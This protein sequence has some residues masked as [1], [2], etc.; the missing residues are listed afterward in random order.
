M[1]DTE[2]N[3]IEERVVTKDRKNG[4]VVAV[5]DATDSLS[6]DDVLW[7]DTKMKVI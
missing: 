3:G 5:V 1:I 7:D 6:R 2:L 4:C